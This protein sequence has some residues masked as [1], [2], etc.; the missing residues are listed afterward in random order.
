MEGYVIN[1]SGYSSTEIEALIKQM[2]GT[3]IEEVHEQ[4]HSHGEMII[5]NSYIYFKGNKND[6]GDMCGND[7]LKMKLLYMSPAGQC[8]KDNIL[9]FIL[10]PDT[11]F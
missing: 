11:E 9:S 2:F 4:W 6:P 10:I 5:Y 7:S 1:T 3:N 8:A